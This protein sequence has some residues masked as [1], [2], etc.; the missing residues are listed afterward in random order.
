MLSKVKHGF[1]KV[2]YSMMIS[3]HLKGE[4]ASN[5]QKKFFWRNRVNRRNESKTKLKPKKIKKLTQT[6]IL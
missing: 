5:K 3:K 6:E 1:H 4:F 2:G